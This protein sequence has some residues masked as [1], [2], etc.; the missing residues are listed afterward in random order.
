MA[1]VGRCDV[2][3]AV[4]GQPSTGKS[5]F[6][7]YVTGELVRIAAWPG[8]TVEQRVARVDFEGRSLCLVDLPGIYGLTPSSPDE[9]VTKR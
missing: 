4:V 3:V 5:T 2:V 9:R 8:T 1:D 7:T 6:F